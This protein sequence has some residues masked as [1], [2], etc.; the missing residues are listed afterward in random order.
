MINFYDKVNRLFKVQTFL[1]KK[2]VFSEDGINYYLLEKISSDLSYQSWIN[3]GL[4]APV[5][6]LLYNKY[7][8]GLNIDDYIIDPD[9]YLSEREE[10][11]KLGIIEVIESNDD[12]NLFPVIKI[13][14]ENGFNE[15]TS[16]IKKQFA[17]LILF[18]KR[19]QFLKSLL[20]DISKKG[21]FSNDEILRIY[22]NI[23]INEDEMQKYTKQNKSNKIK[24]ITLKTDAIVDIHKTFYLD[25]VRDQ[26][27][28]LNTN[29]NFMEALSIL[30]KKKLISGDTNFREFKKIF[31]SKELEEK[32][33]IKW[34]GSL[35][36][37]KWLVQQICRIGICS[38]INGKEKWLVTMHCFK[39]K[40]KDKQWVKIDKH[41]KISNASGIEKN[42][43]FII[44]IGEILMN[45]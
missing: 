38:H 21:P 10:L 44:E 33:L 11:T 3:K 29:H 12:W 19:M 43:L 34:T 9:L 13:I 16:K 20:D 2:H 28:I 25:K 5:F 1:I 30:R 24:N 36:E 26:P 42:K 37:L 35:I 45:L 39:M 41:T 14:D 27:N 40:N 7:E 32:E 15:L 17:F 31:E 4:N 22:N 6:S 18:K 23:K 8:K